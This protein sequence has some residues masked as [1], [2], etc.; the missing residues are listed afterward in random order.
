D[1]YDRSIHITG[2]GKNRIERIHEEQTIVTSTTPW[3]KSATVITNNWGYSN[4]IIGGDFSSF[5]TI[6]IYPRNN[7]S[8][9]H[10]CT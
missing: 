5:G 4:T 3:K 10:V 2:A 6:S 8:K 9:Q 7:C 1:C